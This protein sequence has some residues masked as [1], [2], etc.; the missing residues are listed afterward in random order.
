MA[1]ILDS[2]EKGTEALL[3]V[4]MAGTQVRAMIESRQFRLAQLTEM[5]K[6]EMRD[7]LK[8]LLD[9]AQ[10]LAKQFSPDSF[11]IGVSVPFVGSVN[12]AWSAD[13]DE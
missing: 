1:S 6:Q 12:F 10:E 4:V 3:E 11:S 2:T 13:K 5:Q 9:K 7:R 8:Q